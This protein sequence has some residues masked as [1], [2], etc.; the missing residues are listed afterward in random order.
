MNWVEKEIKYLE[1][2][3]LHKKNTNIGKTLNKSPISISHKLS[4]LGLK[5]PKGLIDKF[6]GEESKQSWKNGEYRKKMTE[7][8]KGKNNPMFGKHHTEESKRKQSETKK[9]L[10][11]EGKLTAWNKGKHYT[12]EQYNKIYSRESQEKRKDSM[13]MKHSG[14][15]NP[16]Y[17]KTGELAPAWL[18]GKSFE[19]Y[20]PD[21]NSLFKE[22][23]RERDNYCCV[24]CNKPQ[25]E[26][27]EKLNVHHVDY[28]KLNTFPQNCV[29][30]CRPCHIRTNSNRDSWKSFFQI[31]LK[32]R[33][34]YEYTEDQKIILDFMK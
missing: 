34:D 9:R 10:H 11:M 5:R 6:K 32:E 13:I 18:G 29:S 26:L 24:V 21:F 15:K 3:Y 28:N 23:I 14:E 19:P 12:S 1:D 17:G 4:R 33:Y 25:E 22:K 2:T 31:L 20:T 27:K 8:V 7:S 30:L 16:M